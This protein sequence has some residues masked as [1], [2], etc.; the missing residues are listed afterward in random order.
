MKKVY[1][2]LAF[3]ALVLS[4]CKR[5]YTCTC[6]ATADDGTSSSASTTIEATYDDAVE[7]CDAGDDVDSYDIDVDC[8]L[9]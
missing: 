1:L 8:E 5:E 3:G 2:M 9:E 6:T 7:A 4:S